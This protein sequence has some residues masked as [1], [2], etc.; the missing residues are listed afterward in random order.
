MH[1]KNLIKE[2]KPM[3]W[4]IMA[5]AIYLMGF[6]I[7]YGALNTIDIIYLVTFTLWLVM[8]VIR[9]YLLSKKE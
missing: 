8:F 1:K 4:L 7:D 6:R 2:I 3:D 9:L 5:L